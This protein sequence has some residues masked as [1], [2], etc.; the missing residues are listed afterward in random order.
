M[1]GEE[2]IFNAAISLPAEERASYLDSACVDSPEMRNRIEGLVRSHEVSWFMKERKTGSTPSPKEA[3]GSIIGRYKLLQEIGEGGFGVVWMAEQEEPIR[4]RVA[5]KIIKAGMDTREVIARFEA[6]RQALA[7]MDHENIAKIFDAGETASGRPFFVMELVRGLPITKFCDQWALTTRQRL[8]L[9]EEVCAAVSHAHQ[10][11][12]IHRDIKPSNVMVTMHGEKPAPKVIDF[13]IAKATQGRLTDRTLFTRV[14]ELVGTPAYMSPEQTTQGGLDVDTRSDIYSLGVLLY[15]MLTGRP[16][17]DTKWLREAGMDEMRRIIRDVE[18]PR[19]SLRLRSIAG[20]ERAVVASARKAD[21]DKLRRLL[22]PDL[23]WIVMKAIDKDRSRRYETANGF[24]LDIQRFLD[25]EPVRAMPPSAGYRFRKFAL[26]HKW[27][28]SVGAA[29][30]VA[31]VS[32]IIM[33]KMQGNTHRRLW[34]RA[35]MATKMAEKATERAE[36]ATERAEKERERAEE[37]R[38]KAEE[39]REK[40]LRGERKVRESG[41]KSAI[42]YA[43]QAL[44]PLKLDIRQSRALLDAQRPADGQPDDLRGPDWRFLWQAARGGA[45]VRLTRRAEPVYS[46]SFSP[47]GTLLLLGYADGELELWDVASQKRLKSVQSAPKDAARAVFAP[48]GGSFA[49][50]IGGDGTVKVIDVRTNAEILHYEDKRRHYIRDL[51]YSSDGEWLAVLP[52]DRDNPVNLKILRVSDG[53]TIMDYELPPKGLAF[54]NNVRISPDKKRVYVSCGARKK[55]ML[56]CVNVSDKSVVWEAGIGLIRVGGSRGKGDD[57]FSAMA[58]SPDGE[59]LAVATGYNNSEIRVYDAATGK[60]I[61]RLNGHRRYVLQLAFSADGS[62]LVS[63]SEDQTV[64]LWDTATWIEHPSPLLGHDDEVNAVA[65]SDATRLVVTGSKNG[66]VMLWD[67]RIERTLGGLRR[68]PS[69]IEK[70][71]TLPVADVVAGKSYD[72]TWWLIDLR[73]LAREPLPASELS[74]D[75]KYPVFAMPG[76]QR[77]PKPAPDR[78]EGMNGPLEARAV[79]PDGK[80]EVV[81]SQSGQFGFYEVASG[82]KIDVYRSELPTIFGVAY[83][84]KGDRLVLTHGGEDGIVLWDIEEKEVR[85]RLSSPDSLLSDV[86]LT[87][88]GN[89]I[90]ARRNPGSSEGARDG[91]WQYWRA[92]MLE[93]IEQLEDLGGRWPHVGIEL[94]RTSLPTLAELKRQME[95]EYQRRLAEADAGSAVE[96]ARLDET[97]EDLE[98]LLR[99]QGRS[100]ETRPLQSRIVERLK[101]RPPSNNDELSGYYEKLFEETRKLL[102]VTLDLLRAENGALAPARQAGLS[103]E[104]HRL[105]DEVLSLRASIASDRPD[106]TSRVWKSIMLHRWFDK[107]QERHLESL[108]HLMRLGEG[109]G[110]VEARERPVTAYCLTPIGDR[111]MDGRALALAQAA[112]TLAGTGGSE[113]SSHRALGLAWFRMG[114]TKEADRALNRALDAAWKS[115]DGN[116][117]FARPLPA[118]VNF[119]RSMVLFREGKEDEARALFRETQA[120]MVFPADRRRLLENP[121]FEEDI[122]VWTLWEEAK[123]LIEGKP[124][125][126]AGAR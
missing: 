4:R 73:T 56:L 106:S 71:H 125:P 100:L 91:G 86:R 93:E 96:N 37:E 63:T 97:L 102:S 89:T 64:R 28:I 69:D 115:G 62:T 47:D 68:F 52:I 92:P 77:K 61:E 50:S 7:M 65:I 24:A 82:K 72:G 20:E 6:E 14:E 33:V 39:E 8:E 9:F 15:E 111:E 75:G 42:L 117:R 87:D 66:E 58:L 101:Q 112:V 5:L 90:L 121:D 124:A 85:L 88:D 43:E 107:G 38:E 70:V 60:L 45:P 104:A 17:F 110:D 67:R 30:A 41:Y 123:G 81:V 54:F 44:H 122:M 3:A 80:T 79:S 10:K 83:S 18:P 105:V 46:A 116:S 119:I 95:V 22:K 114:D 34:E 1:S 57:G 2:D 23:D 59:R 113:A 16:P 25:N 76:F 120:G 19:P 11:G 108:R 51:S 31:L 98:H 74:E 126:P 32:G 99:V 13:G 109:R 49:A 26:R 12:I 48:D 78:A 103:A 36:K 94:P 53:A 118:S 35:E 84:P 55:P 40:A 21:P 29:A 27:G